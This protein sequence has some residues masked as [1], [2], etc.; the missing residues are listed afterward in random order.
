MNGSE[1]QNDRFRWA[2]AIAKL[3]GGFSA[4]AVAIIAYG[5]QSQMGAATLLSQR[6]AAE[7]QL[8]AT[9]FSNLIAPIVGP[10]KA[11]VKEVQKPVSGKEINDDTRDR[12]R[13]LA[14]ML[15]L[16]FHEHFEFKPLLEFVHVKQDKDGK[17]SLESVVRRIRERQIATLL[18]EGSGNDKTFICDLR[19]WVSESEYKTGCGR[20][21]IPSTGEAEIFVKFR[22][23]RS[24]DGAWL[25]DVHVFLEAAS[26]GT[27]KVLYHLRPANLVGDP[28][29]YGPFTIS[30]LDLP[31]TDNTLVPDGNRFALV[32][33]STSEEKLLSAGND[34]QRVKLT[35]VA[36]KLIW[37]PKSYFTA[38]ERPINY[39]AFREKLGLQKQSSEPIAPT[40][41]EK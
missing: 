1:E 5:F 31:F 4:I 11:D 8:R 3:A 22:E 32:L 7:T 26:A 9:M 36:L 41:K 17:R 19:S 39:S 10:G 38:R 14:E 30:A 34:D 6:E 20:K 12:Q 37:F 27:A 24:P 25:V 33:Q 40:A 21:E 18:N 15:A 16:N 13:L 28:I 29:S 23:V 2:D 35:H